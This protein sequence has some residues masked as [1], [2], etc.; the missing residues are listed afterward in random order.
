MQVF[1]SFGGSTSSSSVWD[2]GRDGVRVRRKSVRVRLT[3]LGGGGGMS[4]FDDGVGRVTVRGQGRGLSVEGGRVTIRGG[5]R[6]IEGGRGTVEGGRGT[7]EALV[8]G[9]ETRGAGGG[10]LASPLSFRGLG[11]GIIV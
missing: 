4:V 7:D 11:D 8:G 5:R 3:V 9:I 6:S 2:R 10:G 1:Q